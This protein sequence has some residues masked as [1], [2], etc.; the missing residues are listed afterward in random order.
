M[1]F[2]YHI[3]IILLHLL[4]VWVGVGGVGVGEGV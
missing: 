2:I 4:C 1:Y 3:N